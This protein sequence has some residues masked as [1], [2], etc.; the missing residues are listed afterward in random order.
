MMYYNGNPC[1]A[2]VITSVDLVP[3]RTIYC[4]YWKPKIAIDS[5]TQDEVG[6][7]PV[8]GEFSLLYTP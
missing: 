8:E 1:V 5:K 7:I 6:E 2:R 3:A 4:S